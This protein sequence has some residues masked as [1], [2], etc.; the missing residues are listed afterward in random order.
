MHVP[1]E[2]SSVLQN[3][4]LYK[5]KM[6][7][8]R[9]VTQLWDVSLGRECYD[10]FFLSLLGRECFNIQFFVEVGGIYQK[11]DSHSLVKHLLRLHSS[12]S[13]LGCIWEGV[14]ELERTCG[15]RDWA[16]I[17]SYHWSS[18]GVKSEL[19][20]GQMNASSIG[21]LQ[22][23]CIYLTQKVP[24]MLEE[25]PVVKY[26]VYYQGLDWEKVTKS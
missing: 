2:F 19:P 10:F 4:S 20:L 9:K 13:G 17:H 3:L 1:V 25:P 14:K 16:S 24:L 11:T 22:M 7:N 6:R 12:W 5:G 23:P 8:S 26:L 18:K 15:Q 21:R